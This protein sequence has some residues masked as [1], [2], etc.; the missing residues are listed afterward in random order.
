M[1]NIYLHMG[2]DRG[3]KLCYTIYVINEKGI[4]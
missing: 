4:K 3:T 1:R 2:V